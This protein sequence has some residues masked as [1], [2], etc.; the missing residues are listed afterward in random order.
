MDA[1]D[2]KNKVPSF[3]TIQLIGWIVY[4][5]TIYITFLTIAPPE[6]FLNL[7]YLKGFRA[8]T[9]F[10][11]TSV[12]LRPIY[13][14]FENRFS[15]KGLI[16]LVLISAVIFGAAW[17]AIEGFYV[18][19]TSFP[20]N[21]SNYLARS[22]RIAL[23]YA[24][25][26]TAWSALYLGIKN[27]RSWQIERENSQIEREKALES[28]ALAQKAQLEILRYQL[29]PH[30]LFNALNSIRASVNED[31]NRARQMITQLSEF[32]RHSLLGDENKEIPL[33]E[34]LEAARNYLAIEKI[35]F[36]ENLEIEYDVEEKAEEFPV[37]CFLLNPLVENAVKHGLQVS[38]NPLKIKISARLEG[39]RLV[40]EVAN[41]G[42]LNNLQNLTGTKI[43]L[44]NVR[45]R[46]EK[47]FGEKSSFQ[48]KQDGKF[49]V[50]KISISNA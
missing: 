18:Y 43:G 38:P 44:K 16:L 8:L 25:T 32:F 22:P 12:I 26:L 31:G 20:F 27:W 40:L 45:E 34:E 46:L 23:D 50:A 42:S 7:F 11:L 48:L 2:F 39:E 9:G 21:L 28:A 17:T 4:F 5:A 37:P 19:L 49:V 6:N 3:W 33:R 1:L 36:E 29:N 13:K 15:I 24:M 41:T 10:F 35:R 14:A 30:F 47:L